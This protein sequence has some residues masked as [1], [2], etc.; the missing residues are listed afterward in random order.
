MTSSKQANYN[1]QL[2]ELE[3]KYGFDVCSPSTYAVILAARLKHGTTPAAKAQHQQDLDNLI[4]KI[5]KNEG[6]I[7][8]LGDDDT[9]Q[10]SEDLGVTDICLKA[11]ACACGKIAGD[12]YFHATP[13]EVGCQ[14]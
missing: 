2:N 6:S 4:L 14:D 1:T 13:R 9:K 11:Q 12:R 3:F 8:I 5:W 10:L 7:D